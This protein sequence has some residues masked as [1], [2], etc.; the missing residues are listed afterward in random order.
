MGQLE[1]MCHNCTTASRASRN[2]RR[3]RRLDCAQRALKI[4]KIKRKTGGFDNQTNFTNTIDFHS[5]GLDL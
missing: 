3:P 5:G 2:E 4:T 1:L